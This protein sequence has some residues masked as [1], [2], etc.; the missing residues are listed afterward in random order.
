VT[1]KNKRSKVAAVC[2]IT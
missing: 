1:V 2:Q